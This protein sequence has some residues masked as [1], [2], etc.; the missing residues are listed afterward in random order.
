ILGVD[1]VRERL[2][3]DSLAPGRTFDLLAV[4]VCARKQLDVKTHHALVARDRIGNDG[5]ICATQVR[6]RIHIVKRRRDVE[7]LGHRAKYSLLR[8]VFPSPC[9]ADHYAQV[10]VPSLSKEGTTFCEYQYQECSPWRFRYALR[11]SA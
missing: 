11:A 5:R 1:A 3:S 7:G 2:G 4:L 8:H 6:R 10:V 9:K